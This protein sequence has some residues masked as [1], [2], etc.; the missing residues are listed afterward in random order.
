MA[1]DNFIDELDKILYNIEEPKT[2]KDTDT[3]T[4]QKKKKVDLGQRFV[5]SG[6][7]ESYYGI[8]REGDAYRSRKRLIIEEDE[9][10][11][12]TESFE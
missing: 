2:E 8:H 12:I 11:K 3:H 7:S 6:W 10:G 9:D 1:F 5:P 4:K